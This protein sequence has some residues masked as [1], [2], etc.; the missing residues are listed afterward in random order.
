VR[1]G[2]GARHGPSDH[3]ILV[4]AGMTHPLASWL[5]ALLPDGR[6]VLP[7]TVAM[8]PGSPIGK[9]MAAVLTRQEHDYAGGS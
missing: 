1:D 4:D 7:P 3:A 5:D 6:L 8:P 2:D 9:G